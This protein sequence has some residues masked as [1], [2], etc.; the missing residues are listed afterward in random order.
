[1]N[2]I[3]AI[4]IRSS[5][6]VFITY[7]IT[8]SAFYFAYQAV[9]LS[10]V[11][12]SNPMG[13]AAEWATTHLIPLIILLVPCIFIVS[14]LDPRYAGEYS[15]A[16]LSFP[17]LNNDTFL[18]ILHTLLSKQESLS[19]NKLLLGVTDLYIYLF[20]SKK[21]KSKV[22]GR[23]KWS[24]KPMKHQ[25]REARWVLINLSKNR[26]ETTGQ[27]PKQWQK[28]HC[29]VHSFILIIYRCKTFI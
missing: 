8:W 16:A 10:S 17:Q 18:L 13:I 23:K 5:S 11:P 25:K 24:W 21:Q 6:E 4:L 15:Q 28:G 2:C 9:T 20:F 7:S 29:A 27:R 26:Y 14:V 3:L 19:Q 12:P 22:S 1:M